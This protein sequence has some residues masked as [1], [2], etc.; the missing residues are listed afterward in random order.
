MAAFRLADLA[1]ELGARVVGDPDLVLNGPAPLDRA[2]PGDLSF[3]ANPLYRNL[4]A[5]SLAGAVL[6]RPADHAALENPESRSWLLHDNPYEAFA[7][8]LELFF[9][10]RTEWPATIHPS[11]VIAEDAVLGEGCHVGPHVVIEAGASIGRASVLLAG[12]VIHEQVRIG[13]HCLLHAGSQV[14]ERCVLG[15]RVVLQNGAVIGSEGFGYAPGADGV[16]RKIPQTGIVILADDVEIGAN[17]CVDRA[18]MGATEI[19]AGCKIDNLV[20]VAHNV[21]I[22]AG[23]MVAAL[24]GIAGSARLG[25]RCVIGGHSAI[26]GHLKIGDGVMLGGFSGITASAPDGVRL[27]GFPAVSH[28]SFLAQSAALRKLPALRKTIK[29]LEERL[30]RLEAGSAG[31]DE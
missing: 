13:D 8:A 5:S 18:T 31:E 6:L 29:D 2:G 26:S 15:N 7:R 12:C 14:R 21:L 25:A 17:A 24:T 4:A 16:I 1:R 23:T 20:Q 27:A 9:P 22:G 28:E 19:G 10:P 3:L 30:A 11:A